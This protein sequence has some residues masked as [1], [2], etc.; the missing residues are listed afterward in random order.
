MLVI[1]IATSASQILLTRGLQL[2]PSVQATTMQY[3]TVVMGAVWGVVLFRESPSPR[4]LVGG[5]MVV[6]TLVL[7]SRS[8]RVRVRAVVPLPQLSSA[9]G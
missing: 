8:A 4:A 1:G 6:V 2:A 5:A 3:A 9:E 7:A